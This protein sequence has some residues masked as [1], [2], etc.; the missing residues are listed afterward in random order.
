MFGSPLQARRVA[1]ISCLLLVAFPDPARAGIDIGVTWSAC[2]AEEDHD[3]DGLG[4]MCERALAT[5]FSPLLVFEKDEVWDARRSY[6]TARPSPDGPGEEVR[7]FYALGYLIDPGIAGFTVHDGDSEFVVLD[8]TWKDSVWTVRRAYLSAHYLA[9]NDRSRW[10]DA[11]ELEWTDDE[12]GS[13]RVYVSWRKHANYATAEGC[14]GIDICGGGRRI[15]IIEPMSRDLGSVSER[16]EEPVRAASTGQD[17]SATSCNEEWFWSDKAFCGWQKEP[18]FTREASSNRGTCEYVLACSCEE[19]ESL[20]CRATRPVVEGFVESFDAST[21]D[22]FCEALANDPDWSCAHLP[23][24]PL[25]RACAPAPNS[26]YRQLRDFGMHDSPE[27]GDAGGEA[28]TWLEPCLS[29]AARGSCLESGSA[30]C[31]DYLGE[32][33]NQTSRCRNDGVLS[34]GACATEGAIAGCV[35]NLMTFGQDLAYRMLF[36]DVS[37]VGPW[38]GF[39]MCNVWCE[40]PGFDD[41]QSG[42]ACDALLLCACGSLEPQASDSEQCRDFRSVVEGQ[43]AMV[44]NFSADA[45]CTN[46]FA[47]QPELAAQCMD[48][49]VGGP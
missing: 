25:Q 39:G 24:T 3:A 4:E 9:G 7:I 13:P 15:R 41:M 10:Y 29:D 12:G 38:R 27:I 2:L 28:P 1:P 11:T 30:T 35:V 32:N 19:E 34:T 5:A 17:C 22:S 40:T 36:Y 43:R 21:A 49:G 8:V 45:S 47:Q 20:R 44:G 16:I 33:I 31:T 42:G 46:V 23:T 26:Y 14:A 6:W 48:A 37:A 18:T